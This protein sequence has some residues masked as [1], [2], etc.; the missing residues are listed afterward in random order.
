MA[1]L[2]GFERVPK[3]L[4]LNIAGHPVDWGEPAGSG[5]F[6]LPGPRLHFSQTDHLTTSVNPPWSELPAIV[7]AVTLRTEALHQHM[8]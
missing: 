5:V 1:T 7:S 6:L 8:H 4:W 2:D 3:I